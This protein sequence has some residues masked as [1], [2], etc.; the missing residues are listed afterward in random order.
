MLCFHPIENVGLIKLATAL[1]WSDKVKAI[2]ILLA[3][4]PTPS[5]PLYSITGW[6]VSVG[7]QVKS[8]Q[9]VELPLV[10]Y[11]DCKPLY[12]QLN[13]PGWDMKII[14]G[15]ICGG[16]VDAGGKDGMFT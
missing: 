7:A 9:K 13:Y 12:E 1:V 15:N 2:K 8:L 6:G 16:Y 14:V 11:F 4:E 5:S 10:T 3:N